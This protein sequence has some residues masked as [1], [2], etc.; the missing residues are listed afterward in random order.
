MKEKIKIPEDMLVAA[1]EKCRKGTTVH[2]TCRRALEA[3]LLWLKDELERMKKGTPE[4]LS[5]FHSGYN[6]AV[7]DVC[8]ML[9]E[10]EPNPVVTQ[11]KQSLQGVTLTAGDAVE[12][13]DAVRRCTSPEDTLS[14]QPTD[15]GHKN[16][17]G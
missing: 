7:N 17:A 1:M 2:H 11:I 9:L 5:T 12:L 14:M 8:H 16:P 4:T 3:S 15:Q 6:T 10:P 13:M